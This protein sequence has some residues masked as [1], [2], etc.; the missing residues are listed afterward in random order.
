[1]VNVVFLDI[2][3]VLNHQFSKDKNYSESE[4][5]GLAQDLVDNLKTIINTVD[6]VKIVIS[7]SWRSI[8]T[9][10]LVS[11]DKN[12]RNVLCQMLGCKPDVVYGDIPMSNEFTVCGEESRAKDIKAWMQANKS[13]GI[14]TF[15]II[16]DE[17]SQ[18]KRAFPNNVVDCDINTQKGLDSSKAKEA[19][20]ILTN[21]GKDRKMTNDIF[22]IGDC[23]FWHSNIIKY[24]NRPWWKKD[25]NG[26]NVPDV[27]K[28]NDDMINIWNSVITSNDQ[29]VYVNGD[30]CFGNKNK[31]KDI[32]DK[33]N[34]KKRIVLGNHDK[35]KFKEYYDIGFDRVYDKPI[36]MNNFCILSHEPLQWVKDGD[37][38]MNIYAHVHTQEMYKDYTSNSFCT[39][40]ERLNYKPIGLLDIFEKCQK[41]KCK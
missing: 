30:F 40:A 14:G 1:M 11:K 22:I 5:F 3:G 17:C 18:L 41:Y 21:N 12:W 20:W 27:E 36:I 4:R 29:T 8:K 34:G 25:D 31:V 24:C 16:D 38:Y 23:H 13:L 32:F 15:V 6:F 19:I 2:D 35:C 37:V 28:M 7:S 39:S 10:E 26:I 33:L 9:H